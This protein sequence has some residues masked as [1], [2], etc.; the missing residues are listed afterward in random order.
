M[1]KGIAQSLSQASIQRLPKRHWVWRWHAREAKRFNGSLPAEEDGALANPQVHRFGKETTGLKSI[2]EHHPVQSPVTGH[3]KHAVFHNPIPS[4]WAPPWGKEWKYHGSSLP[5]D[6]L[7]SSSLLQLLHTKPCCKIIISLAGMHVGTE[8]SL[9]FPFHL[10]LGTTWEELQRE[11]KTFEHP[12][13]YF[14][15]IAPNPEKVREFTGE[16]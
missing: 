16:S 2:H 12:C 5:R 8:Q 10:Q 4:C 9:P 3:P 14:S 13:V 11:G 6:T 15:L 1:Y 7:P